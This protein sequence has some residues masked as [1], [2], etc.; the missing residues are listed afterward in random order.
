MAEVMTVS[1]PALDIVA[2][3]GKK[4]QFERGK[5]RRNSKN[6]MKCPMP[7]KNRHVGVVM[8]LSVVI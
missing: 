6:E 2:K 7:Q 1:R 4:Q 8:R 3:R 5:K